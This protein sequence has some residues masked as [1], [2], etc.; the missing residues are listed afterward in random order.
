[1]G[2]RLNLEICIDNEP[3]ANV[4]Y[5]WSGYTPLPSSSPMILSMA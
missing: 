4:Y 2:Q 3:V 5:H 1:M